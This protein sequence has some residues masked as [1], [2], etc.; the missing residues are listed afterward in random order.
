MRL[1]VHVLRPENLFGSGDRQLFDLVDNLAAA[2][3]ALS[4]QAFGVLVG[5]HRTNGLEHRLAREVLT[6]DHLEGS[7]L[8]IELGPQYGSDHWVDI[9]D[10]PGQ[11]ALV[12][13]ETHAQPRFR[14][15]EGVARLAEPAG[16]TASGAGLR[17]RT[18][19]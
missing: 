15:P 1:D 6:G 13:E 2:V 17:I 14:S 9:C 12:V 16:V 4:G 8:A 7:R 5:Q 18:D 10:V 11:V 3:V 19:S